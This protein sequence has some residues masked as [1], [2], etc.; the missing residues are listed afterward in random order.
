MSFFIHNAHNTKLISAFYNFRN[1]PMSTV[2]IKMG[3]YLYVTTAIL[4]RMTI[5]N[6]CS[7]HSALFLVLL[8]PLDP[9]TYRLFFTFSFSRQGSGQASKD[10][11]GQILDSSEAKWTLKKCGWSVRGNG[12]FAL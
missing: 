6:F 5:E 2:N 7:L 9:S 3:Y 4:S 11:P 10:N 12:V 1:C 8:F